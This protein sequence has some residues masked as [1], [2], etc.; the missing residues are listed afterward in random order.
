MLSTM[1][2]IQVVLDEPLLEAA[3]RAAHQAKVNR[4]ALVRQAL[5]SYLRLL[6][7]RE[8]ERL[9]RE[10]YERRPDRAERLEVWEQAA[11]WPVE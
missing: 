11:S 3:D 8:R 5:R 9:D 1:Q 4:S 6:E 2:T 10:G 7:I